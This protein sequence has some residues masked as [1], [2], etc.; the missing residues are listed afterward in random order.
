VT[1]LKR[2]WRDCCR[3]SCRF[4]PSWTI[5]ILC[6]TASPTIGATTRLIF[7]PE[8]RYDPGDPST[9]R[10]RSTVARLHDAASRS[11]STLFTTHTCEGNHLGPTL[12]FRASTTPP[13][14]GFFRTSRATTTTSPAVARAHLTHPRVLQLVMIRCATGSCLPRRRLP[15]RSRHDARARPPRVRPRCRLL[16]GRQTGSRSRRCEDD[17]GAMGRWPRAVIRSERSH[18][19]GRNGTIVF[20]APLRRYWAGSGI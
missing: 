8:P 12:S 3:G 5:V 15:L 14:I 4:T 11:F 7:A 17:C 9:G 10:V 13:T 20:G 2:L 19:A 16:R 18:P 1:H 6:C